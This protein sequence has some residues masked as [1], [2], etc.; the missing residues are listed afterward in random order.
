MLRWGRAAL[1]AVLLVVGTVVAATPASAKLCTIEVSNGV[2]G[3][4]YQVVECGSDGTTTDPGG[5]GGGGGGPSCYLGRKQQFTYEVAFCSGELS[6]YQFVPSRSQTDPGSWPV[7]DPGVSPNAIWSN[8]ACFTQPPA[9]ELVSNEYLWVE[10][11]EVVDLGEEATVAF[12]QLLTPAFSV[13]FNPPGRAVVGIPTWFWAQG[14]A[15]GTLTG[16]SA[17]GMVAVARPEHLEVDPGDGSGPREC[18]FAVAEGDACTYTYQRSSAGGTGVADGLP[19]YTA[20]A[21]LVYSVTY[22]FNGAPMTI[23]GAQ[24]E[25]TSPWQ[26]AALPVAEVQSLVGVSR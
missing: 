22:A 7:R 19:A 9:E 24:T 6:C 20:R 25:L 15:P 12:G 13:G 16:S 4:T 18:A 14:A 11:D 1:V 17:A 3:T 10:P 2:G 8:Q 5:S 26:E 21:R 23:D